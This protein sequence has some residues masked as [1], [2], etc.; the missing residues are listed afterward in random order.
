MNL[1]K[2]SLVGIFFLVVL[3]SVAPLYSVD[4]FGVDNSFKRNSTG[5]INYPLDSNIRE[6]PTMWIK[7]RIT[8]TN[9]EK[10]VGTC[11]QVEATSDY[12]N[13]P[14]Q[15]LIHGVGGPSYNVC[16]S[17]T[18]PDFVE[19]DYLF[20]T[21]APNFGLH[22]A[23]VFIRKDNGTPTV[24]NR[25][26]NI[27]LPTVSFWANPNP[28]NFG[29]TSQINWN[30]PLALSCTLS[31]PAIAGGWPR[32]N[33]GDY[34][35]ITHYIDAN[36]S[37][38]CNYAPGINLNNSLTLV[39]SN[40]P[41][42]V[43]LTA[44]PSS[45]PFN[46]TSNISWVAN[47]S[48]DDCTSSIGQ[49]GNGRI[50]NFTT[51]QLSSDTTYSVTCNRYQGTLLSAC[52]GQY[53]NVATW[54]ECS[55]FNTNQ[56]EC[57][58]RSPS[59]YWQPSIFIPAEVASDSATV[60]V[61]ANA[62]LRF[63]PG[64]EKD[65]VKADSYTDIGTTRLE[66]IIG[67]L[68]V[69]KTCNLYQ[70]SD[71]LN[72]SYF[73]GFFSKDIYN[74]SPGVHTF[75]IKCNNTPQT[76]SNILNVYSQ[77]GTLNVVSCVIPLNSNSCPAQTI[78][79]TTISPDTGSPTAI[80]ENGTQIIQTTNNGNQS[81]VLNGNGIPIGGVSKTEIF[82]SRNTVDGETTGLSIP[83]TLN[84]KTI[85]VS[86]VSGIWDG[87]KCIASVVN[88][89]ELVASIVSPNSA[90]AGTARTFTSTITNQGNADTDYE[91]VTTFSNL[92]QRASFLDDANQPIVDLE[93][94][95]GGMGILDSGGGTAVASKTITFPTART[96]YLRVC[97]DKNSS[98]NTGLITESDE[99]NNCGPWIPVIVTPTIE[100]D[101][102]A[103]GTNPTSVI[104]NVGRTFTAT[105]R[106]QGTASTGSGFQNKFQTA[107]GF[108]DPTSYLGPIDL[109]N[110]TA[111]QSMVALG[112]G[113]TATA[114]SPVITFTSTTGNNYMRACADLPPDSPG[115]IPES[116]A[117]ENNNCG[118][119][120]L[121]EVFLEPT[122]DLQAS[123]P[124]PTIATIDHSMNFTSMISNS[125]N[126]ET[127]NSFYNTFQIATEA[128]GEGNLSRINSTP[129]PMPAL[130]P[131]G[132][133]QATSVSHTFT[134]LPTT[135][136]VRACADTNTSGNG[137]INEL[138][139]SNEGNNCSDWT[140]ITF[141]STNTTG[142]LSAT[143]CQIASGASTCKTSLNWNTINPKVGGVSAVTT[144]PNNTIVRTALS[145]TNFLYDI[146]FGQRNFY[147]YHSLPT[148]T[149]LAMDT[150]TASCLVLTEV[151]VNGKCSPAG[152]TYT[153]TASAGPK[154]TIS[155]ASRTVTS[156]A[157]TTFTVTP[158]SGYVATMSGTCL[159]GSMA[160]NTYT[161]G[162]ITSNCTVRADFSKASLG[163]TGTL[164][165][166]SCSIPLG[167]NTC[168]TDLAWNIKKTEAV[169]SEITAIG[170]NPISLN[171]PTIGGDYS[172]T[173]SATVQYPNR[174][175][176]L[177]NHLKSLVPTV[178]SPLGSGLL[179]TADC[180]A[181]AI[182]DL[183][184]KVCIDSGN[185]M[186]GTLTG[187][188]CEI[189]LGENSCNT[190]LHWAINKTESV[191]SNIT[192]NGMA[193]PIDLETPTIGGNYFGNKNTTVPHGNRR[194]FLNNNGVSLVPPGLNIEAKCSSELDWDPVNSKCIEKTG[195][196]DGICA[197]TRFGCIQVNSVDNVEGPTS[198]IWRCTGVAPGADAVCSEDKIIPGPIT[199]DFKAS[200]KRIFKGR[201]STLSW[202]TDADSCTG[203]S[204]DTQGQP[205]G[206]YL[207]KPDQTTIYT[208]SCTKGSEN[209]SSDA[210]VKVSVI[211]FF[212]I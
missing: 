149:Q 8:W 146:S 51:P 107:T 188:D 29:Q 35:T 23:K 82:E 73:N 92:F 144:T 93:W 4:A 91:G 185:T 118:P 39:V 164:T 100:P 18:G 28:V 171:T 106:N 147:L 150:A 195:G 141:P 165:G 127:G 3:G 211:K 30:A 159:L 120:S 71:P 44:N 86:C 170:M 22:T 1:F 112:V 167:L 84:T 88:R 128:N 187:S 27:W 139:A 15:V 124:T 184:S 70:G 80:Y 136:S 32:P 115:A 74:L 199:I 166:L 9:N 42:A 190:T 111:P 152:P 26:W 189:G 109:Q 196:I 133:R 151:W 14:N 72:P 116:V 175:F 178:E 40:P 20:D 57:S 182:W 10:L 85:T 36:Y 69:G 52:Y 129:N 102:T 24:D 156:G 132:L 204:F 19:G 16:A 193:T 62:L 66:S 55:Y 68:P 114:T 197:T 53:W 89:P 210:E 123:N 61:G 63:K 134:G 200:P 143:N 202:K 98:G 33:I 154:G 67:G 161:T 212:E 48:T 21:S 43:D 126:T 45:V 192:A 64:Q 155:P 78:G 5:G 50:G 90:V 172:G 153:V 117:F 95:V 148:P 113:A 121:V 65:L 119:W 96:Y 162:V 168:S 59:C 183:D 157:T 79:W 125:G 99:D 38:I 60:T 169:A 104:V 145:G 140:N 13:T 41:I 34:N 194:F 186:T 58:S 110:Y 25:S 83:N 46:E 75:Q 208:L 94:A 77:A 198:Y 31:G 122:I 11:V 7:T 180:I 97:T 47:S 209:A 17:A 206:T 105:I 176:Y 76:V 179:V 163:M 12:G 181:G 56:A 108:D 6:Y 131:N 142:T 173:K 138:P 2:K 81:I 137:Q 205:N 49:G 177:Y 130:G 174:R 87:S 135:R 103:G 101:L 191:A 160:G 201:S 207:V 37:I 158:D 54:N 203:S